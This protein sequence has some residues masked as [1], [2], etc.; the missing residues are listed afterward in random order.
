MPNIHYV[1]CTILQN[2]PVTVAVRSVAPVGTT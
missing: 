2:T 1:F